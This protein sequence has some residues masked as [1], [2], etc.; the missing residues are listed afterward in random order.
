[1]RFPSLVAVALLI[2]PPAVVLADNP[3]VITLGDSITRGVR[4]GVKAEETFPSLLAAR[5]KEKWPGTEVLNVGIGG[6][7][8]DGALARLDKDVLKR[9][10]RL[11]T[12]MYGT[13]D[14]Y[15]DKGAKD[16]RLSPGQ[17]RA[18]LAK[19][20]AELRKA[21]VVPVL[22]TEPRWADDARDGAGENPNVRLGTFVAVCREVANAH[23]V[24]LVDHFAHWT[25]AEKKGV[26]LRDWTTDGCHPNAR[27][28][29]E[30]AELIAPVVLRALGERRAPAGERP[31]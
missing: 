24:P 2:G 1:M 28:H 27:G 31:G 15:V 14:S 26:R 25:A 20:V 17:Y 13:N 8:T 6:E 23:K 22:M 10:P 29:R 7:R 4:A 12:V 9:R 3:A 5:L 30:M 11:V 18:N 16:S 19:I 21:G